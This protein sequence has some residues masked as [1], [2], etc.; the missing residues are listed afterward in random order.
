MSEVNCRFRAFSLLL[1]S[2]IAT[3]CGR[4]PNEP[5]R[6]LP[7]YSVVSVL[8]N[9]RERNY[10][11]VYPVT[12]AGK[13]AELVQD[14]NVSVAWNDREVHLQ[15]V[16]SPLGQDSAAY[17]DSLDQIEVLPSTQYRLTVVLP[18]GE[19]I[20]GS[21]LVPGTF[22]IVSPADGDTIWAEEGLARVEV[23][24]TE[25]QGAAGYLVCVERPERIL[26]TG[27]RYRLPPASYLATERLHWSATFF[28]ESPCDSL[29]I[30]VLAF[31]ENY[32]RHVFQG[33]SAAGL[34]GALGVFGSMWGRT[35]RVVLA[36]R[37]SLG[38]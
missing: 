11:F 22:A 25:S 14:A 32:N 18:S 3:G 28:P 10:L 38:F 27:E 15:L 16:H 30:T 31:D 5:A 24:W 8:W 23:A 6:S 36:K 1:V 26:L 7:A 9:V 17:A 33:E 37:Q 20:R 34:E 21:T 4:L 2:F 19:V 29:F 35:I 12:P 13:R